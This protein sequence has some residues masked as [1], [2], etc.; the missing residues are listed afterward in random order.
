MIKDNKIVINTYDE[1]VQMLLEAYKKVFGLVDISPA[2]ALGSDLAIMAEMKKI[3]DETTQKALMQNSP[4]E[5]TGQGLE[6]IC[7]LRGITRK[8]DEHSIS[9]V[10]FS[11]ADGTAI[12]KGSTVA[13]ATTGE[14]FT[15]NESGSISGGTFSVYATAQ[16]PGRVSCDAG[17]LTSTDVIGVTVTNA[18]TGTLGYL[19]ESDSDLRKRLFNY[20]NGLNV[21]EEL[22]INLLNIQDVKYVDI[23]SNAELTADANGIPAKST[24]VIVLGGDDASIARAIFNSVPAD[25]KTFG[26]VSLFVSSDVTAKE[27]EVSF[28]RP[29]P[30]AVTI[31]ITITSDDSF[32]LEDAG[33]IRASV[34]SYFADKVTIGDDALISSLYSPIQQDYNSG[35]EPFKGIKE[36][37]ISLDGASNNIAMAFNKYAVLPPENLTLTVV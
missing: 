29:I 23:I 11:G 14:I 26:D 21:D 1:N 19:I 3:A 17:T 8:R 35:Y 37:S 36:V 20:S 24:A 6:N 9:L 33:V 34:L 4:Y 28:S 32:N 27:Y 16:N 2:S 30:Q 15:T 31:D 10:T 5:A 12:P 13:H 25:K 18:S 22:Y 7:F